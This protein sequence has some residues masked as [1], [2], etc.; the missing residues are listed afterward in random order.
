MFWTG[1]FVGIGVFVLLVGG[2]LCLLAAGK[3]ADEDMEH[4]FSTHPQPKE[5]PHA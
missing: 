1:F 5:G 2:F 3:R 4:M